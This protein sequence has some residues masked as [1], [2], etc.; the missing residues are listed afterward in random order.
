MAATQKLQKWLLIRNI[1]YYELILSGRILY[2]NDF[3]LLQKSL[4]IWHFYTINRQHDPDLRIEDS[5]F[6]L[7][8]LPHIQ[9]V[10]SELCEKGQIYLDIIVLI[11]V[12]ELL[13][14]QE[15]FTL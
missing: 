2:Q 3:N 12:C 5:K 15:N 11:I 14:Q 10:V 7:I 9:F 1:P 6:L 4:H 13:Q 8:S